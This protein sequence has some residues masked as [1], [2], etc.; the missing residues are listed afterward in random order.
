MDASFRHAVAAARREGGLFFAGLLSK[1]RILQAFG[2]A[3]GNGKAG[4]T[5][6]PPRS[7]AFSRSA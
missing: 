7:G 4:F 1:D 2:M 3:D 6:P 5:P